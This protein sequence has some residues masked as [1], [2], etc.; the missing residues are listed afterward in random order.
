MTSIEDSDKLEDTSNIIDEVVSEDDTSNEINNTIAIN[1]SDDDINDSDLND[2]INDSDVDDYID[3]NMDDDAN[4]SGSESD[5]INSD[6]DF[7]DESEQF[8]IQ[9]ELDNETKEVT[10]ENRITKPILTKY[11]FNRI[12]G[13]RLKHITMGSKL[14]ISTSDKMSHVDMVKQEIKEKKTPLIIKR[15]LPNSKYELWKLNELN[16]P[17]MLFL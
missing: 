12:L 1:D 17:D 14:L 13:I 5:M 4:Q 3:D 10:K 11:E 6:D 7:I 15:N 2:D 16:I 8:N 9:S